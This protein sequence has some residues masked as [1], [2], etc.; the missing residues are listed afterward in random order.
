MSLSDVNVCFAERSELENVLALIDLYDRE[1]APR[2][3]EQTQTEVYR[4]L[5]ELGGGIVVAKQQGRI[6]GTC[7]LCLCPNLSWTGR[8]FAIIENVI[9]HPDFRGQGIG[10]AILQTATERAKAQGCYK[11][12]L[13]TGSKRAETLSFYEAAGFQ[14]TK[15]GFQIRFGA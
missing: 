1:K 13:M 5:V 3:T 11:V 9:V 14:P 15:T 10:K 8:P 12:A 4:A 7:T 6:V 2:P